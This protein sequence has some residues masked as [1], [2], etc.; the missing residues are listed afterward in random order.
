METLTLIYKKNLT[1]DLA[2]FRFQPSDGSPIDDFK[3]GQFVILGHKM[4]GE[5][6]IHRPYS[7]SS[8]PSEKRYYEFY[9]KWKE[10]PTFGK[11]TTFLF[12]MNI[13]DT[14]FY[15]KPAGN[16]C[17]EYFFSNGAPDRRQMILI[18]TG[19]GL[20]PFMSYILH[21]RNVG[22]KKKIV[23]IHGARHPLELGYEE[24]LEK[25]EAESNGSWNFRYFPTLSHPEDPLNKDWSGHTGRVQTFIQGIDKHQS[26]LETM[27]GQQITPT[28]SMFYLC[29][30]KDMIDDV[31][32]LLKPI[33]FVTTK[34][35]RI[36]GSFDVEYELYGL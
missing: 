12:N 15:Q 22:T 9:I 21:L 17:I 8:P 5:K 32:S 18:A 10:H 25:L 35:R 13:G 29:G 24:I 34:N 33:N 28:N 16:F 3:S 26:Q 20:A 14:V 19:T 11:F 23:L 27:L 1:E 2:I 36:D 6:I 30:K 4:D 7:I 31:I